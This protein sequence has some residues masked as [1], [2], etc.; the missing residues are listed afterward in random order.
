MVTNGALHV[1]L[2]AALGSVVRNA[3]QRPVSF[4]SG[5]LGTQ[6]AE[7]AATRI[8]QLIRVNITMIFVFFSCL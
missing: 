8:G 7:A 1:I 4:R 3:A 5:L 2:Y 6:M